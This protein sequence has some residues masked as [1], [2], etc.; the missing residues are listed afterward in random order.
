MRM[1]RTQLRMVVGYRSGERGDN[2]DYENL[3][4]LQ[5]R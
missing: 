4:E 3:S 5:A 1:L 2:K